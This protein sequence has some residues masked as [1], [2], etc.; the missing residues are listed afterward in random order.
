[1]VNP[2]TVPLRPLAE[3]QLELLAGKLPF[4]PEYMKQLRKGF[5]NE[6]LDAF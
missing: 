6:S 1:M 2:P 3:T 5:Q 4:L